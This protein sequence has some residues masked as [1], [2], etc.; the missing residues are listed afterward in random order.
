M[1]DNRFRIPLQKVVLERIGE[2]H[3]SQLVETTSLSRTKILLSAPI[4]KD[5]QIQNWGAPCLGII[6]IA[7][8]V[9]K[10]FGNDVEI[11]FYDPQ[12]DNFDPIEKWK[13]EKIEVLGLSLLHYTLFDS[14]V[15][16]NNF[17]KAHPE[18]LIVVGGNEAGA[19]YQD[20]F[21]KAPVDISV[22]AEG[23]ET[24]AKIIEW[25][26][27][28]RPLEEIEGIIYRKHAKPITEDSL[29]SYWR[30]VDFSLYRYQNYWDTIAGLY[31]DPDY[32]KI[33]YVRLMTVSHCQRTCTFCSLASVRNIACGKRV[34]P[35]ALTGEQIMSLVEKVHKQL[36][37]VRTIY[38]CTDDIFYPYRQHFLDFINLY[39]ESGFN[40]RI[41][42]QTSTFSLQK[43]DF[44]LLK[45][46]GC[47]H[48]TL[49]FENCSEAVRKSLRKPQKQSK[50]EEIIALGKKHGIAIY[51][52]II[53]MTPEAKMNDLVEN[54]ETLSK[55]V[56]EDGVQISVEP[57]MYPYRGTEV[58]DQ[59][60]A[61]HYEW[62]KRDGV[63]YRDAKWIWPNDPRVRALC[64]ELIEK[65]ETF[66]ANYFKDLPH[67]HHFKGAT[68]VALISL[69]GELLRKKVVGYKYKG[70]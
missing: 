43:E 3:L 29:W 31:K 48:I 6:R 55:W 40:Y 49:G 56:L 39:K 28:V 46:I 25:K 57:V 10:H 2:D 7:E 66:V 47:Q 24:F 51:V 14:L 1:I 52:L 19:N 9:R 63:E 18:S 30:G 33:N 4:Q 44:P 38:F 5:A 35:A 34:E 64:E 68:G 59:D 8:Y 23:E 62:E 69:L 15:F 42:I 11:L 22:T 54:Y 70:L 65:R 26:M 53:L 45:S 20:I 32:E 37:K 58:F 12:I 16:I 50:M 13:D 61:F 36:P 41:L 21:D 60:A 67:Q 17:K 27:G